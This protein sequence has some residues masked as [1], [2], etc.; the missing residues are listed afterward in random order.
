M[1]E[2]VHSMSSRRSNLYTLLVLVALGVLAAGAFW[3]RP[4][5]YYELDAG[6]PHLA[7]QDG[8]YDL[9][10]RYA[11]I[12]G[13][14]WTD[15]DSQTPIYAAIE[16]N[17]V[18]MLTW[19]LE[20]GADPNGNEDA[21]ASPLTLAIREYRQKEFGILLEASADVNRAT[22]QR[23]TPLHDA[24]YFY[25]L[26]LV[27]PLLT[28]GADVNARNMF[29]ATPL[30]HAA[31]RGNEETLLLLLAH[32]GDVH[33]TDSSHFT[34]MDYAAIRRTALMPIL[35]ERGGAITRLRAAVYADDREVIMRLCERLE[36]EQEHPYED[37]S[38]EFAYGED[39]L[40]RGIADA[41]YSGS[42][43]GLRIVLEHASS[44]DSANVIDAVA[45]AIARG[46]VE[47]LKLLWEYGAPH[48]RG[49][50]PIAEGL[51]AARTNGHTEVLALYKTVSGEKLVVESGEA[52]DA[53]E[54]D[55]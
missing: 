27:E 3:F 15:A 38:G 48:D 2:A 24:I 18:D 28:A 23:D 42:V 7:V 50:N 9:L 49:F 17:N 40:Q 39:K 52:A 4:L 5:I 35:Q 1:A 43:E 53:G 54:A 47:K 10:K 12:G 33:V 20:H 45:Y 29:G 36:S 25:R 46:D 55:E 8:N 13:L 44:A 51:D 41:T 34:P 30:H 32:G 31:R 11:V 19:L 22:K 6:S 37:E 16:A 14:E 26:K 21:F